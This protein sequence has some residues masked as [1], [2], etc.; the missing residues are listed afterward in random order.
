MTEAATKRLADQRDTF[1]SVERAFDIV[2]LIADSD[3]GPSLSAVA[4]HL[5]VNKSIADKLLNSLVK[6]GLVWRDDV[7]Q[8]FHLT[9]RISNLGL[10]RLQ[11][12]RLLD[13]CSSEL[14]QLA[15]ETGELIRLALVE[16]AEAIT[17]V[18]AAVGQKRALQIAPNYTLE[19]GLHAHAAGKAWVC[20]LP[21]DRAWEL[22]KRGGLE[23]H[24]PHTLTRRSELEAELREAFARG[25]AVSCDESEIGVGAVA[26]PI[27]A[28]TLDGKAECVGSVSLGAPSHRMSRE[29]FIAVGP[30]VVESADRLGRQWPIDERIRMNVSTLY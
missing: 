10:K 5:D 21:F 28:P 17:W 1:S 4:R 6:V 18:Y 19:I 2:A 16:R 29:Q 12:G 14:R 30:R 11:Q 26:A 13:L 3:G 20:T 24:T 7:T 9:Y 15:N 22:M 25:Y 27:W 8:T 23:K